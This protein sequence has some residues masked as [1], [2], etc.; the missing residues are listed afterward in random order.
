MV[1][2]DL[3]SPGDVVQLYRSNGISK[4][5]IYGPDSRVMEALR[6]SGIK[7]VLGVVNQDI[8]GLA[9]SQANAA[10]WVQTNVRPYYPKVKI[11]YITVGNEV[12]D[13]LAQSILPAM[14]NLEAAL[15]AVGLSRHI[16]VTTC[17]RLDVI[18]NSFPP[19]MGAFAKPHM[20]G[21]T[22][23]LNYATFQSGTTVRDTG[24]GLIYT[25]LFDAMVDSIYAALEKAN[26]PNV[27]VVVSETGWP[28]AGGTGASVQIAQT[29][30]Q[31]LINHV[32]QGTPKRPGRPLEAFMFSMFNENEK[33]GEL[34]ERNFGLFYPNK[35]PVYRVTFR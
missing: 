20:G 1:G 28:S 29:Y 32:S 23:S 10:S 27:R 2:N 11:M 3:P 18:T 13:G 7:L 25:N 21:T 35:S 31:G 9:A 16:K 22:R 24:N 17:L 26:A 12:E 14:Y 5:R 33:P 6:G 8:S 4:M 34:M 30:N 19:S 15:A